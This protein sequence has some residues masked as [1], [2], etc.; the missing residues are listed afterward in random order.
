MFWKITRRILRLF[1]PTRR[2]AREYPGLDWQMC[3]ANILMQRLIGM[4][5]GAPFMMHYTSRV[6]DSQKIKMGRKVWESFATSGGCYI[7]ASGGLEIGDDTMWAANVAM[8][9]ANHDLWD[10][11]LPTS[12]PGVKIGKNVWIGAN[13]TILPGVTIGDHATIGANSVVSRDIPPLTIAAGSPC[14]VLRHVDEAYILGYRKRRGVS[15]PWTAEDAAALA[16]AL[17][18]KEAHAA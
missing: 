3:L 2:W 16:A 1:C 7:Q 9:T 10:R 6:M 11:N 15:A 14:R 4:N 13:V 18:E 12:E 8:L 17:K 5:C